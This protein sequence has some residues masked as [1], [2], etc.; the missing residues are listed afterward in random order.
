[1]H[2]DRIEHQTEHDIQSCIEYL[3]IF[4]NNLIKKLFIFYLPKKELIEIV[5]CQYTIYINLYIFP[6]IHVYIYLC[7]IIYLIDMKVK[8]QKN[9][10]NIYSYLFL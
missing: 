6:S 2:Q 1:M 8:N 9:M 10:H 7:C 3:V 4:I 5:T